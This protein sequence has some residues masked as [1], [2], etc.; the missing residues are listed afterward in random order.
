MVERKDG[1]SWGFRFYQAGKCYKQYASQW[2]KTEAAAAERE[3][4]V[5]LKNNPPL[6]PTAL[7]SVAAGYLVDMAER[8]HNLHLATRNRE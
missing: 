6:P 5:E 2:G 4:R 1:K 8:G 3:K 7:S